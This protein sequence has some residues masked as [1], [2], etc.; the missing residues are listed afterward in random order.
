MVRV[1]TATRF[2]HNNNNV[3]IIIPTPAG[4]WDLFPKAPSKW[5]PYQLRCLA[6]SALSRPPPAGSRAIAVIESH[7]P[8]PASNVPQRLKP[9]P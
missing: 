8:R 4:P 3:P 6:S 1:T 9:M 7:A 5:A 2:H